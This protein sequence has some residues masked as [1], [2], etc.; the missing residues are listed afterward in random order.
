M[1]GRGVC[2]CI[3]GV[4]DVVLEANF[5]WVWR[6]MWIL[7]TFVCVKN[8]DVSYAKEYPPPI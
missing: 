1:V 4:E 7:A 5:M 3:E 2:V 6:D 8:F